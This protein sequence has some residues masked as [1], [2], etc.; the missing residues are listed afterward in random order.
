MYRFTEWRFLSLGRSIERL[1]GLSSALSNFL[2]IGAPQGS[3]D[4]ALEFADSTISHRRR[5]G[6]QAS[7]DSV[8]ELLALDALNP[9][10]LVF[11]LAELETHT[12]PLAELVDTPL[13]RELR[14]E[15]CRFAAAFPQTPLDEMGP[16]SFLQFRK[17]I[18]D[19][20]DMLTA[21]FLN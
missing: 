21:A 19:L 3:L 2:Q 5:Y 7:R 20:S 16:E 4:L 10:S 1:M 8:L 18:G 12:A 14:R 15:V 13:V 6:F 9:R 17:E 11:H